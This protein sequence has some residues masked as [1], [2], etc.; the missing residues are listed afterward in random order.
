MT[1]ETFLIL[2]LVLFA[3]GM[4]F[5]LA[6]MSQFRRTAQ[7]VERF[8][9]ETERDLLPLLKDLRE[10]TE[11]AARLA[12]TAEEDIGKIAPLFHS[13]GEAGHS[14][15][16]LTGALNTDMFRYAGS[17]L[18]FWLGMRSMKKAF[19]TGQK[20]RKEGESS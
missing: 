6:L 10:T 15:H 14:L 5:M 2:L 20:H 16:A 9:D 11:R 19:P 4:G 3:I 7:R 1:T 18:G 8:I 17:A 13:L 12:R